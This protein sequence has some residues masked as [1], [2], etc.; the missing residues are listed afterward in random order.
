VQ[1][2][3]RVMQG[4]RRLVEALDFNKSRRKVKGPLLQ[5][6]H[7]VENPNKQRLFEGFPQGVGAGILLEA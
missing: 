5:R 3:H 2:K 7:R 6:V 4:V 1:V